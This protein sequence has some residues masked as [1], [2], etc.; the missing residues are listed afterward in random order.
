ME[1]DLLAFRL[2]PEV[3]VDFFTETLLP[4]SSNA[5]ADSFAEVLQSLAVLATLFLR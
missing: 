2:G 1:S 4:W 3:F 5:V